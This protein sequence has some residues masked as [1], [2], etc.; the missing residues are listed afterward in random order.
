MNE[1]TTMDVDFF[2]R[3]WLDNIR[4]LRKREIRSFIK[5]RMT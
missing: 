1:T 4:I 5:D 3:K 2:E